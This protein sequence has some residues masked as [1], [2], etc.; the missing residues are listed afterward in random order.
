M[1]K[2][3]I[4]PLDKIAGTTEC[5]P[6]EVEARYSYP[7][8]VFFY[9]ERLDVRRLQLA[10]ARVL[11]DFP[12]Y[13]GKFVMDGVKLLIQHGEGPAVFETARS[14]HS[15]ATLI[16]DI[17]AGRGEQ[18]FPSVSRLKIDRA[19]EAALVI[20][21]TEARDGCVLAVGWN[22]AVGDMH[23]TALLLRAWAD[24]CAGR[25]YQTPTIVS[26]RD[27]FLR[28]VLPNPAG[29][30][31]STRRTTWF[32][33]LAWRLSLL[34]PSKPVSAEFTWQQLSALRAGLDHRKRV[35][36]NDALCAHVYTV[37]R[38]LSGATERTN[39]CLVV[40]FRKRLGLSDKL[41]GNMTSLLTVPVDELDSPAHVA[42]GIREG[43]EQYATKHVNYH[44]TMRVFDSARRPSE[45]LRL[46]SRQFA[47]ASGDIFI[48]NWNNFGAYELS[49]GATVP[50][51]VHPILLGSTLPQWF[52]IVYELPESGGLGI[53]IGL[54]PWLAQ[55]WISAEAQALLHPQ[56]QARGA[57]ANG[58]SH[59]DSHVVADG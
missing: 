30:R 41:I 47:P 12:E 55:R 32:S 22:H 58:V 1:N 45:R 54:P 4:R 18:L 23:S 40:N 27:A 38:H 19:R 26:D 25:P 59:H 56:E 21:L 29:V 7:G 28:S 8:L 5:A 36:I 13:A 57:A 6:L 39:L 34:L 35:T 51:R 49:F 9:P 16:A 33:G 11:N 2:Q 10:L 15:L 50:L 43:L 14:V 53:S 48:T 20:R 24:A 3:L 17:R 31:S 46:I 44:A 37:L 52:M 42:T